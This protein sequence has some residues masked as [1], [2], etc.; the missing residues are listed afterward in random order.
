MRKAALA[1]L[2]FS[3]YAWAADS[4]CYGTVSQG[5]VENAV[6]LPKSGPNFSS[7]SGLG[8][9][10]GRTY[11]HSKVEQIL[12]AA[13][14]ALETAAPGKHFV[15]GETGWEEGGRIRPH[16]THRNGTSV[17]FMV[18]V[19]D[20]EGA[21][22]PLPSSPLNK[23]GYSL[24]FDAEGRFASYQIA[25]E[26]IGEHLYQLHQAARDRGVGLAKVIFDP[27]YMPKLFQTKHG[28]ELQ[29][30]PFMQKDAWV[31]HDE[32]YHVDFGVECSRSGA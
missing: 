23:F 14:K 7:Y 20:R 17:D 25:L 15:Y 32:H 31:R 21:S 11:V 5:R 30:L 19:V 9:T 22:V 18:P 1:L 24:E 16:R 12:V 3:S 29:T 27:R 8:V 10:L 28:A 26:A 6:Q 4:V 2:L 13:Y